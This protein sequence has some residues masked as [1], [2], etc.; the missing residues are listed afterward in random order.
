MD[1]T[2][3]TAHESHIVGQ[4]ESTNLASITDKTPSHNTD[5]K[6]TPV[7]AHLRKPKSSPRSQPFSW[8]V[9][10]TSHTC[11]FQH[12][13]H[14][15][16]QPDESACFSNQLSKLTIADQIRSDYLCSVS[17]VMLM[18]MLLMMMM[19]MMMMMLMMLRMFYDVDDD[20][21]DDE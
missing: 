10:H 4:T 18:M 21:D 6:C 12:L 1:L 14:K 20:D 17:L 15:A 2:I 13:R 8:K 19:M 11:Q 16:H 3:Y 7:N 5:G 9:N